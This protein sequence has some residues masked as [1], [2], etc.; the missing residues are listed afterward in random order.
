MDTKLRQQQIIQLSLEIIEELG[1]QK[2]TMK[3]IAKRSSI[4]EQAIYRHFRNKLAIL[5]GVIDFFDNCFEETFQ[6]IRGVQNPLAQIELLVKA[7][8]DYFEQNPMVATVIFS[9]EIFQ[10][11][12]VL[13]TKIK[14]LMEKRLNFVTALL[15][16]GQKMNQITSQQSAEDLAIIIIGSIRFLVKYLRLSSRLSELQEKGYSLAADLISMI[17]VKSQNSSS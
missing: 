3:E 8:F 6:K 4:S 17:K 12:Q 7:H 9:E 11:E 13:S 5:T 15:T 14:N 10:N 1:I 2:L 16:Q